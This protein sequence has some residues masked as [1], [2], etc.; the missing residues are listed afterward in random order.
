MNKIVMIDGNNVAHICF[1]SAQNV[2]R[3]Q[4]VD[5]KR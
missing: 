4:S 3:K 2:V 5:E 1:H